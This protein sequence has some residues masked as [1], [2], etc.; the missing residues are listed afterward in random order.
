MNMQK[1]T[2]EIQQ[3]FD[4]IALLEAGGRW[5]NNN[6]YHRF[7][8]KQLPPCCGHA[9]EIGC[10]TGTFARLLA[11]RAERVLA[12][13]LSPEMVRLATEQSSQCP[14]ICYEVTDVT[15]WRFPTEEFDYIVS[16]AAMHHLPLELTLAKMKQALKPSGVLVV[17]DLY[18][19]QGVGDLL[20]SA[21]AMP[22]DKLYRIWKNRRLRESREVRQ[23]WIVHGVGETYATI[24]QVRE[25]CAR[26]LPGARVRKHL[27]WRYS[28]V[29][30]H[31]GATS[32]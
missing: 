12:L 9:L 26:V 32:G 15:T 27:L 13:D 28:L 21:V 25:A 24:A 30:K 17:L 20:R 10:G 7:L 4:R 31:T 2:S 22:I 14:N 3:E 11:Q 5:S 1:S 18:Q 8:L 29:W 23:A 19:G 6:Y 16:I